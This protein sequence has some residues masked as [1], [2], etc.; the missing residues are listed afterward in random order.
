MEKTKAKITHSNWYR[1][2]ASKECEVYSQMYCPENPKAIIQ[3]AHGMSERS[4]RYEDFMQYLAENGFLV[5]AN[6]HLGHGKT[7]NG[8]FGVFAQ[9]EGGFDF[10][11]ED[12]HRLF[13]QVDEKY[14]NLPKILLGHSMGSILSA[15]FA[16]RHDYLTK[17]ILMGTPSY[18]VMINII[19]KS[20]KKRVAKNGYNYKSKLWNRVIWGK[21]PVD[22]LGKIK[23]YSWLT[24]KQEVV[25]QFVDDDLC[26]H[27]FSDSANLELM[28]GLKK[29][30]AGNWG[31]NIPNIPIMFIAGTKDKVGTY[32]KGPKK[33][34]KML[35]KTHTKL[36]LKLIEG[37]RHEVLSEKNNQ[38]CYQYILNWLV[39]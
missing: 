27:P 23:R 17:L 9:K 15:L 37:D 21:E 14:P 39:S 5:C 10:V 8:K 30:G 20:L 25:E 31:K 12:I 11:I 18:N 29:W 33:Y 19:E 16:D 3:I 26:G 4:Q 22:R 6:D 34:Y 32:G 38:D 28:S 24:S 2:S 35:S 1:L 13:M 36:T 7:A